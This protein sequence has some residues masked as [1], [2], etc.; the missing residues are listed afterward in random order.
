MNEKK[1]ILVG[2]AGFVAPRHMKAI[3]DAGGDLVAIMDPHDSVGIIDSCFPKAKYFSEFERFDRYCTDRGDISYV[4]ICSPNRYHFEQCSFGL[5]IGAD[6]ICEKPLCLEERQVDELL[7][8]EEQTGKRVWNISQ[9]RLGGTVEHLKTM[10]FSATQVVSLHYSTPR[11]SWYNSSWKGDVKIS[12]GLTTAIGIHLFDIL[13]FLFGNEY[14]IIDWH[15]TPEFCWG[16]IEMNGIYVHIELSIKLGS[17]AQRILIVD[18]LE[19][20]L[21]KGFTDLH[22]LSYENIL[23]GKGIGIQDIN[24]AIILCEKL[25]KY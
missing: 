9:L 16:N 2:A 20:E 6:V 23:N 18:E 1:F 10:D 21:S 8:L 4:S 24:P 13:L 15:N 25:R 19:F 12:G 5:N 14:K 3:K 22:T 17:K 7:K 11:G